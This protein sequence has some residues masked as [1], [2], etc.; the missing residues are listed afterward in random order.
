MKLLAF[1]TSA[2]DCSAALWQNGET[3]FRHDLVQRQHNQRILPMLQTLLEENGMALGDLDA[4]AFGRGPGSFT[5]VR[6]ATAVA[7]GLAFA[8]QRPLLPVSTLAAV[9][10]RAWREQGQ[11]RTLVAFDARMGEVY[12]AA[13]R[14]LDQGE[15]LLL[16]PEQVSDPTAVT[17]PEQDVGGAWAV[18]GSGWESY[19]RQL[20][21]SLGREPLAIWPRLGCHALDLAMIAARQFAEGAGVAAEQGQ[22]V[23]L[24][25]RVTHR[26]T[27]R[28]S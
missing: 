20:R 22:P 19:P 27:D 13:Y 1:D 24:R 16:S 8:V 6:I 2:E 17:I 12:W 23:Y 11:E 18:A 25:N 28:R 26:Q 4:L 7:Q 5:G 15:C 14:I 3:C 21:Q 10:H 9:A